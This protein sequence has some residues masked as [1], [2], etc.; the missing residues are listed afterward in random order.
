M[1]LRVQLALLVKKGKEVLVVTQDLL[2]LQDLWE[3][4]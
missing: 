1:V 2:A 3:N 4:G